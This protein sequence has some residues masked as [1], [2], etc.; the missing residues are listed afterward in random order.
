[1][2]FSVFQSLFFWNFVRETKWHLIKWMVT[3]RFNPCFS[4]ISSGSVAHEPPGRDQSVFQSLFFWN[5]V[6]ESIRSQSKR[7]HDG[8]SILVFLE[9]RPGVCP[10]CSMPRGVVPFQSLFFWNFVRE[11][12]AT[13]VN[14]HGYIL[15][16]SLFFWNFVWEIFQCNRVF[17]PVFCFNPC[18]SGIS[19]GSWTTMTKTKLT[20]GVS[21][22]VFLE[23]RLGEPRWHRNSWLNTVSILVFLEFRLGAVTWNQNRHKSAWFQS[24]FFWNFV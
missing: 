23:F 1:M 16:Q 3:R 20:I 5:F 21:I 17:C 15:F 9:F 11:F 22:L 13:I 19:S 10:Y 24:L 2:Q 14:E 18:F 4:G 6:R 8:V 12:V 7:N